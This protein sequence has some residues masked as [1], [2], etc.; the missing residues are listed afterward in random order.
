MQRALTMCQ[1]WCQAIHASFDFTFTILLRVVSVIS[2]L[3]KKGVVRKFDQVRSGRAK[4]QTQVCLTLGSTILTITLSALPNKTHFLVLGVAGITVS[5]T[6]MGSGGIL[7]PY[8][9]MVI[10]K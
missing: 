6:V 7:N 8:I 10:S 2:T 3:H 9:M 4:T 1:G 5:Y